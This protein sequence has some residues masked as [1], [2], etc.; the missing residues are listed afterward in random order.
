MKK[1]QFALENVTILQNEK[2]IFHE[3]SFH[4]YENDCYGI[5]C[6]S[7]EEKEHI[8]AFFNGECEVLE[9][10]VKY[11]GELLKNTGLSGLLHKKFSII[12]KKSKLIHTLSVTENICIFTEQ[13]QWVHSG[14]YQKQTRQY[15][16]HFGLDLDITKP[17]EE[18]KEKERL[19]V[20]MLKAYAEGKEVLMLVGLSTFL[21]N[22]E[23]EEIHELILKFQREHKT[24]VFVEA[25]G[26]LIFE[27][28]K[29][30]LIVKNGT[31]FGC[32]P[33]DFLQRTKLQDFLSERAGRTPKMEVEKQEED[34]KILQFSNIT[35]ADLSN[36]SFQIGTGEVLKIFCLDAQSIEGIRRIICGREKRYE[37][38]LLLKGNRVHLQ[39]E[40][41][42]RRKKIAYCNIRAYKSMLQPDMSVRDN[43]MLDLSIKEPRIFFFKKY[44]KSVDLYIKEWIGGDL[45]GKKVRDLTMLQ[46]QRLA[47]L[48]LYL[49]SPRVLVCEHP[50]FDAD[51]HMKKTTL[52][53]LKSFHDQG[54]A[55]IILTMRL[56]ALRLLDGD[57]LYMKQGRLIDE[58]A[59]YQ[60]LYRI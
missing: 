8:I 31:D 6:D 51:L 27:W 48:K 53:I 30:I 45:A 15:L 60:E 58:D 29:N 52:D 55:V 13:G 9:G 36:V 16:D 37:G 19:M 22:G 18:L 3:F 10:R 25:F 43:V 21:Q 17:V 28:S 12:Q 23:L 40:E 11:R 41:D 57:I 20:E 14:Y 2:K 46:R 54:I 7:I 33:S 59:A 39:N 4:L 34:D 24:F 44:K 50:F 38:E 1:E 49:F 26:E 32:F 47:F 42:M 35:S 56:Q 5:L